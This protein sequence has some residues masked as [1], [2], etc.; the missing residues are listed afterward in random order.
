M[1]II[2]TEDLAIIPSFT[3]VQSVLRR[4]LSGKVYPLIQFVVIFY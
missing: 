4:N 1:S 3:P 2:Y